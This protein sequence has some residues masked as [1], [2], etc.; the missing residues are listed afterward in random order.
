MKMTMQQKIVRSLV[1]LL[2]TKSTEIFEKGE[3]NPADKKQVDIDIGY[4]AKLIDGL[5]PED[6]GGK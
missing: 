3:N 4:I 6:K 2:A 1:F 5:M